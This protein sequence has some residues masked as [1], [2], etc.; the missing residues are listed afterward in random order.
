ML[1]RLQSEAR[2]F[3]IPMPIK[4]SLT[5]QIGQQPWSFHRDDFSVTFSPFLHAL[6]P[7]LQL[8]R[9]AIETNRCFFIHLGVAMSIHPFVLELVLR[10]LARKRRNRSDTDAG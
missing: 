4:K 9:S 3:Y 2:K 1:R 6:P 7:D 8:C 5:L 10:Y